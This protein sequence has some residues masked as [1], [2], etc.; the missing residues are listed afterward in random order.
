[1]VVKGCRGVKI[2]IFCAAMLNLSCNKCNVRGQNR[3]FFC[4]QWTIPFSLDLDDLHEKTGKLHW[5][6]QNMTRMDEASIVINGNTVTN[7]LL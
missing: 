1:M 2:N 6:Q 5:L 3:Y 4:I 7:K